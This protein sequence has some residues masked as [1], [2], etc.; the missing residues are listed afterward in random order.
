MLTISLKLNSLAGRRWCPALYPQNVPWIDQLLRKN[1]GNFLGFSAF[2]TGI[3]PRAIWER[4][5]VYLPTRH[6]PGVYLPHGSSGY[7]HR[8]AWRGAGH[9]RQL[10]GH[11]PT[12]A[13]LRQA[14]Q[15]GYRRGRWWSRWLILSCCCNVARFYCFVILVDLWWFFVI[16]LL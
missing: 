5:G 13:A 12:P 14:S 15:E 3:Q 8:P 1:G 2:L 10:K 7:Q 11:R 6:L 4:C 9:P 16:T